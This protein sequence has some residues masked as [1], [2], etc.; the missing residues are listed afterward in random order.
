MLH[1]ICSLGVGA[2]L[3]LGNDSVFVGGGDGTLSHFQKEKRHTSDPAIQIDSSIT[4]LSKTTEGDLIVGT[5]D[6]TLMR[7]VQVRF[8]SP[9]WHLN[10]T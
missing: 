5:V 1:S 10:V 8:L 9:D 7:Q 2:M 6:G 4:S 3:L